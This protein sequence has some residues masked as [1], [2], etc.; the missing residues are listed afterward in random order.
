MSILIPFAFAFIFLFS[1]FLLVFGMQKAWIIAIFGCE[2]AAVAD[3]S[4]DD[5]RSASRRWRS[6]AAQKNNKIATRT[7]GVMINIIIATCAM[8][9]LCAVFFYIISADKAKAA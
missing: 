8:A 2:R 5:R 7:G 4:I 6:P 9:C 3:S 1:I